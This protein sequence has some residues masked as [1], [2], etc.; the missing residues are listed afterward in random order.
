MT[1]GS[2]TVRVLLRAGLIG[3]VTSLVGGMAAGC[4]TSP[5]TPASASPAKSYLAIA[6]PANKTL[7]RSF[8]ELDDQDQDHDLAG[9]SP[10]LRKIAATER[11]F[12][13]E[14]LALPLPDRT[15]AIAAELVRV[16]EARADLTAQATTAT[17]SDSLRRYQLE[18]T[19]MNVP[20]ETQVQALRK[21]LGLP[22]PDT[23]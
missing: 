19:A 6:T 16:N 2:H 7:D 14:L 13:R 17:T 5:A 10:L 23:D 18:L 20:V 15:K 22:P 12:D 4:S 9:S 3:G 1:T 11:R 21:S 8:D